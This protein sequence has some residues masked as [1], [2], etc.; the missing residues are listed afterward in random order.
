LVREPIDP[1]F[2]LVDRVAIFLERDVLRRLR[3]TQGGQ[4]A[5]VGPGPARAAG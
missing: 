1:A 3:D 2:R 5:A 4:P